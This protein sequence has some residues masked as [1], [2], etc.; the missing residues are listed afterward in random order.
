M[1]NIHFQTW[2]LHWAIVIALTIYFVFILAQCVIILHGLYKVCMLL[3]RH[4]TVSIHVNDLNLP[5]MKLIQYWHLIG[6]LICPLLS[7]CMANIVSPKSTL[8]YVL[9]LKRYSRNPYLKLTDS[10]LWILATLYNISW[11]M[12]P[13][14][15]KIK[16]WLDITSSTIYLIFT[17]LYFRL[18]KSLNGI[19]VRPLLDNLLNVLHKPESC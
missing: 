3:S 18:Q 5:C 1:E 8:L 9:G 6:S 19:H 15:Q 12:R 14:R 16:L 13:T 7:S 2:A 17:I 4:Q 10:S 11:E